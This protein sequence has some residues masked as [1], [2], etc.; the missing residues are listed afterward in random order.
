MSVFE[1][2][3]LSGPLPRLVQVDLRHKNPEIFAHVARAAALVPLVM[4]L[5][6]PEPTKA[7]LLRWHGLL[8]WLLE[9][10]NEAPVNA[11]I[12]H[13]PVQEPDW[14][15]ALHT[16]VET[17]TM[18]ID[19]VRLEQAIS[20]YRDIFAGWMR[21]FDDIIG[22][23][24]SAE[25]ALWNEAIEEVLAP[26]DR[27]DTEADAFQ[28]SIRRRDWLIDSESWLSSED[29]A[30]H[31]RD[32]AN[33]SDARQY[34]YRLRQDGQILGVRHERWRLHPACQFGEVEG[35]LEPRAV[36]AQLLKLLPTDDSGWTQAFWLFQPTGRL[37]GARPADVLASRPDD[38]LSA[39][40]KDFHCDCGV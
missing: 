17:P 23:C 21:T 26:A 11:V 25:T 8:H 39:A 14:E 27:T 5:P 6:K 30:K 36:M 2:V 29:I 19:R 1:Y 22:R 38:V 37:Q 24:E 16:I 28:R 15:Q 18:L 10:G 40:D 12:V 7:R 32:A 35:R 33:E 31:V 20:T 9:S 34:A 13:V 4:A 3:A